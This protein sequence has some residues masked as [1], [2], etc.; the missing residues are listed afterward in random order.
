MISIIKLNISF[1]FI[2][3]KKLIKGDSE[4][5]NHVFIIQLKKIV[6][7][8]P[9]LLLCIYGSSCMDNIYTCIHM[10]SISP[11]YGQRLSAEC[12]KW[13]I[14]HVGL[15][16]SSIS[17]HSLGEGPVWCPT[18]NFMLLK[19]EKGHRTKDR[20]LML[21]P[22]CCTSCSAERGRWFQPIL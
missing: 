3:L 19:Q 15:S 13:M 10:F 21:G 16:L 11:L 8:L 7:Y 4:H 14:Y 9:K 18:F 6:R 1:F 12:E 5:Q 2:I 22:A 20:R 17:Q